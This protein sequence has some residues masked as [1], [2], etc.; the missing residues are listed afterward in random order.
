[1]ETVPTIA[2]CPVTSTLL[3]DG[4]VFDMDGKC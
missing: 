4:F 3:Y 2:N 1:M